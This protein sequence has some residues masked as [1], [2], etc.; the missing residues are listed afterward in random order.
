MLFILPHH[1][2]RFCS[3]CGAAVLC[4]LPVGH[5]I[6]IERSCNSVKCYHIAYDC[7]GRWKRREGSAHSL[8]SRQIEMPTKL[9]CCS[10]FNSLFTFMQC[11]L[12]SDAI[13]DTELI[14]RSVVYNLMVVTNGKQNGTTYRLKLYSMSSCIHYS[15]SEPI[16]WQSHRVVPLNPISQPNAT[17][18]TF[19]H[20]KPSVCSR[21]SPKYSISTY[22]LM[23]EAV[24]QWPCG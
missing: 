5:F 18:S 2:S 21:Q 1:C 13:K 6:S 12:L 24:G 7:H 8:D 10:F 15:E 17:G 9:I 4:L 14:W 3:S 22:Q 19:C 23:P 20:G 11:R 16:A